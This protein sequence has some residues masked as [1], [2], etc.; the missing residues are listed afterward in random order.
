MTLFD[1]V[2]AHPFWTIL[3]MIILTEC[4]KDFAKLIYKYRKPK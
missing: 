2:Q 4:V 1:Y 3:Y